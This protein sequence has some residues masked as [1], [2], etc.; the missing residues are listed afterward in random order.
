MLSY[1]HVALLSSKVLLYEQVKNGVLLLNLIRPEAFF[2]FS[3][4]PL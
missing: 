2:S 1:V 4:I 3:L